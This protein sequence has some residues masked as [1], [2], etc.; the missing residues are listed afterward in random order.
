M[1]VM[2][3]VKLHQLGD[4]GIFQSHLYDLLLL[5]RKYN[6]SASSA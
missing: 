1:A 6:L 4:S 3:V 5:G 2:Y